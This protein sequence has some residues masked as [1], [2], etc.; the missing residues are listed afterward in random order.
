MKFIEK[1]FTS[2]P[3]YPILLY[4]ISNLIALFAIYLKILLELYSEILLFERSKFLIWWTVCI[5]EPKTFI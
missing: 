1:I 5:P 2:I 4:D 3:L